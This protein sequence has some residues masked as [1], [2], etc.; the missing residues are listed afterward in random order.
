MVEEETNN[1]NNF[2]NEVG[3]HKTMGGYFYNII[4]TILEMALGLIMSGI[5]LSYLYPYPESQGYSGIVGSLFS[6]FYLIFDLGTASTMERFVS[7]SR[8][9]DIKRMIKYI[10]WFIWYQSMTGL[11]QVSVLMIYILKFARYS[12]LAYLSWLMIISSAGQFPGYFG[13]FKSTLDSLQLYNKSNLLGFVQGQLMGRITEVGFIIFFK[14]YGINNP[15][16]GEIMGIAIG[17]SV[18]SYVSGLLALFLSAWFF[19]KA[20]KNEGIS[21]RDCFRVEFDWPLIKEV[22]IFGLKTGLP[23]IIFNALNFTIFLNYLAYIPQYPT[24]SRLVG[25]TSTLLWVLGRYAGASTA[26][27]SESYLN[28]KKNLVQFYLAQ[29]WRFIFQMQ[30]FLISILGAVYFILHDAFA[31][32]HILYY[33]AIFPFLFPMVGVYIVNAFFSQCDPIIIGANKP[34]ANFVIGFIWTITNVI[35]SYLLVVVY[36]IPYTG[37]NGIIFVLVYKDM[38][39]TIIFGTIK[40]IF[41]HKKIVPLKFPLW[42]GVVAPVSACLISFLIELSVTFTVYKYLNEKFGFLTALFPIFVTYLFC[43]IVVYFALHAYFGGY[44]TETLEY[45]RRCVDI[46]GPSKIMVKFIYKSASKMSSKSKFHNKFPIPWEI[47]K[48]E[49]EELF[50]LK[51]NQSFN[52]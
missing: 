37:I 11:V 36:K 46:S 30:F 40:Y 52:K 19:S 1:K 42:Q 14:Y 21:V 9:K 10:Q 23:S 34:M 16:I 2:W 51:K 25:M 32:L 35:V 4:L 24:M 50:M 44:D 22:L 28:N 15:R 20:M 13:V 3:F 33:N 38:I 49:A 26:L 48:K 41:I 39:L 8:I 45:L 12:E 27:Y 18:G 7:E 47:A 43:G 31:A 17:A 29:S 6:L 5:F